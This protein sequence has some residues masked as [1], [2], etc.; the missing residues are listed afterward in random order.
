MLLCN[1][2]FTSLIITSDN[3]LT[4]YRGMLTALE[5]LQFSMIEEAIIE[6]VNYQK[7]NGVNMPSCETGIL[8]YNTIDLKA[9]IYSAL[10]KGVEKQYLLKFINDMIK[11]QRNDKKQM[12]LIADEHNRAMQIAMSLFI[13]EGIA[14]NKIT[15]DAF[16][17]EIQ[18]IQMDMFESI[19]DSYT[20]TFVYELK[21]VRLG[22]IVTVVTQKY[23]IVDKHKNEFN[24]EIHFAALT[25]DNDSNLL[26]AWLKWETTGHYKV[27]DDLMPIAVDEKQKAV[28]S[29]KYDLNLL[30]NVSCYY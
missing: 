15:L 26:I 18:T 3:V 7:E 28:L 9:I 11:L 14:F 16:V 17:A 19:I 30:K 5:A 21:D 6:I 1:Y 29:K 23:L 10:A 12:A 8:F 27:D 20:G 13:A 24:N 4:K 22:R 2:M 25:F